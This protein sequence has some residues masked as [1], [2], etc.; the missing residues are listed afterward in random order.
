MAKQFNDG[1]IK[2][3]RCY[4]DKE[5]W[6][7]CG[8]VHQNTKEIRIPDYF[9]NRPVIAIARQAFSSCSDLED[10]YIG[11]NVMKVEKCAFANCRKLK[12]VQHDC[13]FLP[14]ILEYRA[15]SGCTNLDKVDANIQTIGNEAFKDC[16]NLTEIFI[17]GLCMRVEEFAF[18]GCCNLS[19]IT[20]LANIYEPMYLHPT[21]FKTAE[22]KELH[23][24]RNIKCDNEEVFFSSETTIYCP[25]WSNLT[26]LGFMG[27]AVIIEEVC[28]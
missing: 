24:N 15:F 6:E 17:S 22:I 5:K 8:L 3:R 27:K 12:T 20:F 23:I 28:M 2:Y 9:M 19:K 1:I 21:A 7:V 26:N 14:L 10:V 13:L 18:R 25:S 16:I 11:H 4:H